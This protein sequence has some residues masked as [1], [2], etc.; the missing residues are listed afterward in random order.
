[1]GC[2]WTTYNSMHWCDMYDLYITACIDGK[3]MAY[4]TVCIDGMCMTY[5]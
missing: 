2:V 5:I 4:I 1:M 3:C